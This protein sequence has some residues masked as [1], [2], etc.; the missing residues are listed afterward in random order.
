MMVAAVETAKRAWWGLSS[1]Y[2]SS[3]LYSSV[4]LLE[5]FLAVLREL[6]RIGEAHSPRSNRRNY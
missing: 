6:R 4:D 3:M 5:T 2:P 1:D